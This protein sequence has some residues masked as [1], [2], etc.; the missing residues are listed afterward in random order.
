MKSLLEESNYR[1]LQELSILKYPILDDDTDSD[2]DYL[3]SQ[4]EQFIQNYH[5]RNN[6]QFELIKE[7][8]LSDYKKRV[9]IYESFNDV[10]SPFKS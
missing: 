3:E 7:H 1:Y 5:K 8:K 10:G 2:K 4:R 6:R 9:D